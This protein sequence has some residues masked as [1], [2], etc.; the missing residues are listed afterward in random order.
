MDINCMKAE[1]RKILVLYVYD[2]HHELVETTTKLV[3]E[4]GFQIDALCVSTYRALKRTEISWPWII[5]IADFFINRLQIS[6]AQGLFYYILGKSF[7]KRII[8]K[9]DFI[10]FQSFPASQTELAEYCIEKKKEYMIG[11]WGSDALRADEE[12]LKRDKKSLDGAKYIKLTK[13]IG[14]IIT[15]FYKEQYG[16]DYSSKYKGAIDGVNSGNKDIFLLNTLTES[17]I[18]AN[19]LL[20]KGDD[21]SKLL[22]TIGYNGSPKQ[23]HVRAIEV[24][25]GLSKDLKNKIHLVLPMTYGTSFDYMGMV[26]NT[27]SNLGIT[28]TIL[29]KFLTNKEVCVLRK[30]TDVFLMMQDTDAFAGSVR[31]H[32]YCQNVCLIGDWLDYPMAGNGVYYE[33]VN[34]DNLLD[35]FAR[36]IIDYDAYKAKSLLNKERMLPFMT[37]DKYIDYTC[38]LYK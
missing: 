28:Y 13:Q 16:V 37:W 6:R 32:L 31:S 10:D 29:D 30:I 20:F 9:Y 2:N 15:N 33:S 27:V 4:R 24:L 19:E 38:N 1:K 22:V 17:D 18:I 23:N 5:Y 21:T 12:N 8:D 36:V 26:K 35:I 7:F 3:E 34:W 11:F 14:Q 25:S